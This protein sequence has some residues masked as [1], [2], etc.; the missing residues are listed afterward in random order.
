LG[1]YGLFSWSVA[2]RTRE[3]AIR[4]TLGA[5]PAAVGGSVVGQSLVLV[6]IGLAG[7]LVLVRLGHNSLQRVLFEVS[8]G[9][10]GS[11]AAAAALLVIAAAVACVPPTLRAMRVDPVKGLRME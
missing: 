2:L 6:T 10:L 7:G 1:V 11:T 8:P 9:D 5:K 4:M 3:L